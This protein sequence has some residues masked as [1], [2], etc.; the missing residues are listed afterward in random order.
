MKLKMMLISISFALTSSL[1]AAPKVV[2]GDDNR[3]DLYEVEDPILYDLARSTAAMINQKKIKDLN[4]SFARQGEATIYELL[5]QV[6]P[7]LS[8]EC[9]CLIFSHFFILSW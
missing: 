3:L 5:C 4:E 8:A 1:Y 9:S 7:A 2:Y 6:Y